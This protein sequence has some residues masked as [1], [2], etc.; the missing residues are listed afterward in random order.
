MTG[1]LC[2]TTEIDTTP[3]SHLYSNKNKFKNTKEKYFELKIYL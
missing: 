2:C 1:S 3:L